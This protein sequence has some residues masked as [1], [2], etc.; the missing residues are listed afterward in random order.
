M[1]HLRVSW[2]EQLEVN[3]LLSNDMAARCIT[4]HVPVGTKE[5]YAHAEGWKLFGKIVEG[6]D[7]EGDVDGNGVVDDDD[8]ALLVKIIMGEVQPDEATLKRADV[9]NDTCI[10]AADLVTVINI[11]TNE[12]K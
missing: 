3:D 8:R 11:I 12:D 1:K 7:I 10:N 9:N 5:L 2:P 6:N 4:L